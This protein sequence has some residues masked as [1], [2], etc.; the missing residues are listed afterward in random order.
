[1]TLPKTI[2]TWR[3]ERGLAP[4]LEVLRIMATPRS[5]DFQRLRNDYP[6]ATAKRVA[7]LPHAP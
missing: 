3:S 5:S 7:V 4:R 2:P 6:S 1:M